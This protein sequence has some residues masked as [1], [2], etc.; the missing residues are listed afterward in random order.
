[1]HK[2][3]YQSYATIIYEFTL[4]IEYKLYNRYD[5]LTYL[6]QKLSLDVG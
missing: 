3:T 6:K 2:P 4:E 5:K 1:M